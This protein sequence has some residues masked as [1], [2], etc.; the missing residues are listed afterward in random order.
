MWVKAV[1]EFGGAEPNRSKAPSR[2]Q[3]SEEVVD[4]MRCG[5]RYVCSQGHKAGATLWIC[6]FKTLESM[7]SFINFSAAMY[8][9]Y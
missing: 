3:Q 7:M 9:S 5:S 1:L 6:P 8:V 4:W 2:G